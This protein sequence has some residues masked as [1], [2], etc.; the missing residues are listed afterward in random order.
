MSAQRSIAKPHETR[1]TGSSWI[2]NMQDSTDL[3][4]LRKRLSTESL[5]TRWIEAR[6]KGDRPPLLPNNFRSR[7]IEQVTVSRFRCRRRDWWRGEGEAYTGYC[8]LLLELLHAREMGL[9]HAH[10][11]G[12]VRSELVPLGCLCLGKN[13]GMNGVVPLQYL[14]DCGGI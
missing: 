2:H 9:H 10:K 5:H 3:R 14:G 1:P 11:G 13:R 12:G 4:D 7:V 6:P 8:S